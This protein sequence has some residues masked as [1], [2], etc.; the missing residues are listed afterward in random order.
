MRTRYA[1]WMLQ[2]IIFYYVHACVCLCEWRGLGYYIGVTYIKIT[3]HAY[4]TVYVS[5]LSV[6]VCVSVLEI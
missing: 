1:G 4:R 5:L 2:L 3:Q 6:C